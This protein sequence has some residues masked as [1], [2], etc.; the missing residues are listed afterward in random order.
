MF[1]TLPVVCM[2]L[3]GEYIFLTVYL[4][5]LSFDSPNIHAHFVAQISIHA[6]AH[7]TLSK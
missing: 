2:I 1:L 7:A 4:N 3:H 6:D 5:L